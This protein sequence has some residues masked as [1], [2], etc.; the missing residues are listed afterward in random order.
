LDAVG[1][2]G[3]IQLKKKP[4]VSLKHRRVLFGMHPNSNDIGIT[5]KI[6]GM[7]SQYQCNANTLNARKLHFNIN[8]M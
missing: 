8:A 2:A 1:V 5:P 6:L 7:S 3:C 4:P